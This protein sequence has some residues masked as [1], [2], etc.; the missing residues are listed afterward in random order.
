MLLSLDGYSTIWTKPSSWSKMSVNIWMYQ[1]YISEFALG[2]N[3]QNPWWRNVTLLLKKVEKY[4]MVDLFFICLHFSFILVK[5]YRYGYPV[6]ALA[7]FLT[8][9]NPSL[10]AQDRTAFIDVRNSQK[11]LGQRRG[12]AEFSAA[13]FQSN[14]KGKF[15]KIGAIRKVQGRLH[16]VCTITKPLYNISGHA[17]FIIMNHDS[18][19]WSADG[20]LG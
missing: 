9:L 15:A 5:R 19:Y 7:V 11:Q 20:F 10:A 12:S 13:E 4:K 17:S 14:A 3:V 16:L 2:R 1:G 18:S 8:F 6:V